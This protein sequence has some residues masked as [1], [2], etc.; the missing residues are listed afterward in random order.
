MAMPL[1]SVVVVIFFSGVTASG[2]D[3]TPL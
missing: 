3:E 2:V 1:A